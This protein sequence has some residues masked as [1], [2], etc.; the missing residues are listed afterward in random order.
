[1]ILLHALMTQSFVRVVDK[2]LAHSL[3]LGPFAWIAGI[4]HCQAVLLRKYVLVQNLQNYY[5]VD[6]HWADD[7][8][9]VLQSCWV[10]VVSLGYVEC[11]DL[12]S[13]CTQIAT[14]YLLCGYAWCW[15]PHYSYLLS[16]IYFK[17]LLWLSRVS[18]LRE[19]VFHSD[20]PNHRI[21][22]DTNHTDSY[23]IFLFLL[24]LFFSLS[25]FSLLKYV[26]SILC[27]CNIASVHSQSN[28]TFNSF[29]PPPPRSGELRGR[30]N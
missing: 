5:Y 25:F 22:E 4:Q 17:A 18:G 27:V 6:R 7:I 10:I 28:S 13:T 21:V 20:L 26:L 15:P 23:K 16:L 24:S 30:R 12:L 11:T 9:L 2:T 14:P 29:T 1:M 3:W 19:L 8:L